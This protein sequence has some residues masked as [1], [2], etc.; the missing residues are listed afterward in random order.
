MEISF[1]N[2]DG[3]YSSVAWNVP[4]PSVE[5]GF[6]S[7]GNLPE[8]LPPAG[9]CFLA[10]GNA[11]TPDSKHDDITPMLGHDI[12]RKMQTY[13]PQS[14][15]VE[16]LLEPDDAYAVWEWFENV[17][18][19]GSDKFAARVAELGPNSQY[20]ISQWAAPPQWEAMHLGRYRL[21]GRL[22]MSG[23]GWSL[24]PNTVTLALEFGMSLFGSAT[25]RAPIELAVEF[26]MKLRV[27]NPL[28][29]EFAMPLEAY[30]PSYELREDGGRELRE[31]GGY[32]LRE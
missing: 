22:I 24:P 5:G 31:D 12:K 9:L 4:A 2:V 11:L 17:L 7:G 1:A 14:M 20:F 27:H 25:V 13:A 21:R 16:A 3:F 18:R 26:A 6:G 28:R 23:A 10:A 19:S 30:V 15:E 29:V 8:L 32:E